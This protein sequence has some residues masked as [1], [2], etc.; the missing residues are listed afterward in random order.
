MPKSTV[1]SSSSDTLPPSTGERNSA[2][3]LTAQKVR[4]IRAAADAGGRVAAL[5][6]AFGVSDRTVR[7]I[8]RRT[9]W[10]HI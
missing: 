8:A 1:T 9:S 2:A 3:K 4:A 10:T 6:V 5:A 7:H